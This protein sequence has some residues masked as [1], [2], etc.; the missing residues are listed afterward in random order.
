MLAIIKGNRKGNLIRA[1]KKMDKEKYKKVMDEIKN[2]D[3]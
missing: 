2:S 3:D 1:H